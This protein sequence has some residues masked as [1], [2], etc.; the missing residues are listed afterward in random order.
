MCRQV[1]KARDRARSYAKAR[2][3]AANGGIVICD[4]F[5]CPQV[6]M[7]DGPQ[8]KQPAEGVRDVPFRQFL[9]RLEQSW[10]DLIAQPDVLV[11]LKVH[12]EISVQRKTNEPAHLVRARNQEIWDQ[13]WANSSAYVVDA[14]KPKEDV[15]AELKS[16]VWSHL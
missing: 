14:A 2:R 9:G 1:C 11:V 6:T 4:R 5:P 7:A 8:I 16:V 3:F 10:Y 13:D 15:L 12:P